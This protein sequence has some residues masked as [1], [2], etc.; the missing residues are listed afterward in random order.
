[1]SD[2]SSYLKESSPRILELEQYIVDNPYVKSF[3]I[4]HEG[5]LLWKYGREIDDETIM[6]VIDVISKVEIGRWIEIDT[7]KSSEIVLAKRVD[8]YFSIISIADSRVSEALKEFIDGFLSGKIPKCK[9][10]GVDL[11][12]TVI[13]C[14]YCS[15]MIIAGMKCPYCGYTGI[16]KCPSCGSNILP[17]GE[18][19]SRFKKKV[20]LP[21]ITASIIAGLIF[22]PTNPVISIIVA[23][24]II[25]TTI[26]LSLRG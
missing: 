17:S 4:L 13:K 9:K 21:G 3:V 14:P 25:Y 15:R 26:T 19:V 12:K 22:F 18:V 24:S 2:K 20:L 23:V 11:Y 7:N 10:C 8:K 1:M 5:L 6:K 16:R